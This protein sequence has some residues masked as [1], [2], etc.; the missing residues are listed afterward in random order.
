[1]QVNS[2]LDE[3]TDTQR[4]CA[5]V[6]TRPPEIVV[7]L[8]LANPRNS[9]YAIF[10]S[11]PRPDHS[12]GAAFIFFTSA[13]M[14]ARY[15]AELLP[16]DES[17]A[18]DSELQWEVQLLSNLSAHLFQAGA[19]DLSNSDDALQTLCDANFGLLRLR[20]QEEI[21]KTRTNAITAENGKLQKTVRNLEADR[22]RI[23]AENEKLQ[24][25]TR[26]L[27]T[28]LRTL[29]QKDARLDKRR[30]DERNYSSSDKGKGK[31]MDQSMTASIWK[32]VSRA[33]D[34]FPSLW[35]SGTTNNEAARS[36]PG[37]SGTQHAEEQQKQKEND[38][39]MAVRAQ[40]DELKT[41]SEAKARLT[42]TPSKV[43]L[44]PERRAPGGAYGFE[45]RSRYSDVTRKST[46][47]NDVE[48]RDR[49]LA[50]RLQMDL[51]KEESSNPK[52]NSV[53]GQSAGEAD[54]EVK[55]L[56]QLRVAKEEAARL[57][58][59]LQTESKTN[60]DAGYNAGSVPRSTF[61]ESALNG[62]FSRGEYNLRSRKESDMSTN[63]EAFA[64]HRATRKL[65]EE[66][67]SN[68]V[69]ST[70]NRGYTRVGQRVPGGWPDSTVKGSPS[71]TT[72]REPQHDVDLDL[73]MRLQFEFNNEDE[74]LRAQLVELQAG[75]QVTFACTICME[76]VPEDF[77]AR[78][79]GC[80]HSFC[81]ECLR[82]HVVA[83][84]SE[85]KF[86]I[87]CPSCSAEKD[88]GK[89]GGELT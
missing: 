66:V 7:C 53:E 11:H 46:N 44:A 10:D 47:A 48:S 36:D 16:V 52:N 42:P 2:A 40:I 15:I 77:V 70:T 19:R 26:E 68:S 54:Q 4:S 75:A 59:S 71:P 29:R 39:D 13:E 31:A 88:K 23:T 81:R 86:P 6:L 51:V 78:V 58:Y 56:I 83:Q 33:S 85:N 34:A 60:Y 41:A 9:V 50:Y 8:R 72:M 3:H 21:A 17:L 25:T 14:T 38:S 27:E 61:S 79:N 12:D 32:T 37:P 64:R 80:K 30:G 82:G 74:Q 62:T 55:R 49:K 1:M 69:S 5:L 20:V 73:A 87:G 76:E 65:K 43:D 18:S 63:S 57:R 35:S 24:K 67:Y 28:Q 89:V 45:S 84:I 22:R